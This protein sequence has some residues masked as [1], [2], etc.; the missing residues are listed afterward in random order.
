MFHEPSH[1]THPINFLWNSIQE[2]LIKREYKIPRHPIVYI[3]WI[4]N[5]VSL[6]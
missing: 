5:L 6:S 4:L 3:I 2:K 1:V